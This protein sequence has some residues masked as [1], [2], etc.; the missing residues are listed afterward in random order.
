MARVASEGTDTAKGM[1]AQQ[2]IASINLGTLTLPDG[3]VLTR[4]T[5]ALYNG[6]YAYLGREML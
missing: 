1:S 5:E 2:R 6:L 4:H 3:E